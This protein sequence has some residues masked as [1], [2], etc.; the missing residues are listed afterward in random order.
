MAGLMGLHIFIV[1]PEIYFLNELLIGYL[2]PFLR[3]TLLS[4]SYNRETHKPL[5]YSNT[6]LKVNKK[7]TKGSIYSTKASTQE[8][9]K[10]AATMSNLNLNASKVFYWSKLNC[11]TLV[12]LWKWRPWAGIL[13]ITTDTFFDLEIKQKK[14]GLNMLTIRLSSLNGKIPP[15][16][17]NNSID[18]FKIKW[19][20]LLLYIE[21]NT[22]PR[23]R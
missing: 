23:Y 18:S 16:W 12:R 19:K 7:K 6:K 8:A 14:V 5:H 21:T 22:T 10:G 4:N 1:W 20:E 9:S 13:N 3:Q 11:S 15:A 17:L 2:Q